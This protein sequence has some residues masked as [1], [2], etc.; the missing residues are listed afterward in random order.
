MQHRRWHGSDG[1]QLKLHTPAWGDI[2]AHAL[3]QNNADTL[4]LAFTG[5]LTPRVD[6]LFVCVAVALILVKRR[7][8]RSLRRVDDEREQINLFFPYI[9]H[10]RP[11]RQS[12]VGTHIDGRLTEWR[13]S[14]DMRRTFD[15]L[16]SPE[17]EPT[18][19]GQ[20]DV[21]IL[22]ARPRDRRNQQGIAAQK[23]IIHLIGRRVFWIGQEKRAQ[24][25]QAGTVAL[26]EERVE[27]GQETLAQLEQSANDRF[28]GF[29]EELGLLV[30]RLFLRMVAAKGLENAKLGPAREQFAAGVAIEAAS[31]HATPAD[32]RKP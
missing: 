15:I 20:V 3:T 2:G 5:D 8:S 27:V 13:V 6:A 21:A 28:V 24:E 25:R 32:S 22:H 31:I 4:G 16:T 18:A 14:Q 23:L 10:L 11:E 19:G 26:L 9:I 17:V 12:G 1:T 30:A 29:A 7:L